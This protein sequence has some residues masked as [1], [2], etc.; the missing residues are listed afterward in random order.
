[1][2][3][4]DYS[5]LL[6]LFESYLVSHEPAGVP[7]TLYQ[8][9][10]YI[11]QLGGKRIRPVLLLMAY[12]LWKEDVTPVLPA[13][14]AL[15]Y[16]HNFSLM[17][18]D[19]MD[20][21][22]LRRGH[23]SVHQLFGRNSAIL[24]G[25]AML[26]LCFHLLIEA[27]KKEQ[28]GE[29]LVSMM[30]K[31]SLEICEGQQMDMDFEK[32]HSISEHEYLEMIRK[33]TA[34]LIGLS[35]RMGAVL[36]NSDIIDA[37]TL[38]EFGENLGLAFQIRDDYLDV[39]GDPNLT[40]KQPG[41]DILQGKKNFL[42]VRT[43]NLLNLHEQENFKNLYLEA[44]STGDLQQ[45]MKIYHSHGIK[46]YTQLTEKNYFTIALDKLKELKSIDPVILNSLARE[47]FLRDH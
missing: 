47:I 43:F 12:N 36:A 1:M 42:Y 11:N 8:P 15:E 23:R 39:F 34:C 16:F 18:D 38:Y 26:I 19:I 7:D 46:E 5:T 2:P 44:N 25:D 29:L 17:H 4:Q 28:L 45:V 35:L 40:G 3:L 6:K 24:S 31:T 32:L 22:P 13:A 30:A 14:M 10:K 41:G 27:G 37:N 9:M 20:E 21:A 33:K